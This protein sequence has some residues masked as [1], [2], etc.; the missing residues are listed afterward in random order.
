[1]DTFSQKVG[2]LIPL[3]LMIIL[4]F[5]PVINMFSHSAYLLTK[6]LQLFG[7]EFVSVLCG[8]IYGP[9][10]GFAI[11]GSGVFIGELLNYL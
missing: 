11:A 9:G 6:G 3:G 4:S 1:M 10:I 2:W 7:A 8:V 5:P